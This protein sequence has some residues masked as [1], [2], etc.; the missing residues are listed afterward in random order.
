MLTSNN[1]VWLV[2]EQDPFGIANGITTVVLDNDL[3]G[4]LEVRDSISIADDVN[5]VDFN[6][7]GVSPLRSRDLLHVSTSAAVGTLLSKILDSGRL[8]EA[9]SFNL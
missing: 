6:L 5:Y 2:G 1:R 4:N 8:D 7:K 9:V 3:Y